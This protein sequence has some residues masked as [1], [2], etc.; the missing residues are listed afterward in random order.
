VD[1]FGAVYGMVAGLIAMIAMI[2]TVV[3]EKAIILY[4]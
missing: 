4:I 3:K 2:A 1:I